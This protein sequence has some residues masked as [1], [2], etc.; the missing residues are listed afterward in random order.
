MRNPVAPAM[1]IHIGLCHS[2]RTTT[3]ARIVS[4]VSVP[5]TAIP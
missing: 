5:V 3:N 2:V 1:T 4:I